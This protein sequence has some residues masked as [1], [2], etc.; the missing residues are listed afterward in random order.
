MPDSASATAA[1]PVAEIPP[2]LPNYEVGD[3]LTFAHKTGKISPLVLLEI[4]GA[5]ITFQQFQDGRFS[6]ACWHA[7]VLSENTR[8][9]TSAENAAFIADVAKLQADCQAF[10]VALREGS[11]P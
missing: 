3:V 9:M 8:P 4:D 5:F 10:I 11:T 7:K 6:K 2:A 1:T